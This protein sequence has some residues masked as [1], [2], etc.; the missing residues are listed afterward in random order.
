MKTQNE[1]IKTDDGFELAV[2]I[3]EPEEYE[4]TIVFCHGVT[5]CK[6]GRN[7]ELDTIA[8]KLS[9]NGY[10]T[11]QFDFRGHGKSSG[12]DMDVSL[13]SFVSDLNTIINHYIDNKKKLYFL[14]F[15]FG[16]YTVINYEFNNPDLQIG[17]TLL[18]SPAL[19][20]IHSS[21]LNPNEAG[22]ENNYNT[23]NYGGLEKDGYILWSFKNWHVSKKFVEECLAYDYLKRIK[24]L[25]NRAYML[26]GTKDLSV[27]YRFNAAYGDL[28]N[29]KYKIYE[30]A[31]HSLLENIDEVAK[32]ALDY[33]NS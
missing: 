2:K 24:F 6:E 4:N 17:K 12:T 29:I 26:L 30:N 20:P 31:S 32:E 22:F 23:I 28:F 14:G 1:F 15:S 5:N 3:N 10:R 18:I 11:I 7:K 21:F 13:T 9:Q 16:G 8:D 33:F 25:S 19:D 27:D